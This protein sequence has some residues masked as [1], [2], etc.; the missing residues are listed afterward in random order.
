MR[1]IALL[2]CLA[3]S[4]P[5]AAQ[6][7][8][9]C[10]N[11]QP[12]VGVGNFA[13]DLTLAA[14]DGVGD[15]LC[16]AFGQNNIN[17]D[18]WYSWVAP[19]SGTYRFQ[20]C[21]LTSVD[22]KIAVYD[23]SCAGVVIGCN[24]D[25]CSLQSQVEFPAVAGNTYVLRVGTYPGA[26]VGVG[27]F[28][29]N[30]VPPPTVLSTAVSPI[31]GHTYHLIGG[32]SWTAAENAAVALGGHLAT[33][34]SQAEHDWL[35]QTFANYQGSTVDL[36]IGFN[37]AALEGT[38][39]WSSGE[40]VVYTNWDVG[41]PNNAGGTEDYANLRKN[42]PAGYW[43]DLANAPTGYHANPFGVV[44]ILGNYSAFCKADGTDPLVTTPCPCGN[45]GTAGSGCANSTGS[46]ALLA[47]SGSTT[48][49]TLVFTVS[50]E[51]PTALSI[52]L[53]GNSTVA[54]GVPFGDGVR[55]VGGTLKRL[56]VKNA[57]GGVVSAP[58]PGDDPVATRSANLGDVIPAGA[59]R[60]YQ[61]YSRDPNTTFCAAPQGSTFNISNGIKVQ[62]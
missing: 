10:A 44:E 43:N 39:V 23:G 19:S 61:V 34:R 3:L 2:P 17:S 30:L 21:S 20:T 52:F 27:N 35:V 24:D 47:A 31:N 51:L 4:L 58:A 32:G 28:D 57:S 18:V 29:L 42:N 9:L 6:G 1:L 49:D 38:F 55:C 7:A 8:D 46:G 33:V 48:P 40:P 25:T 50:G 26:V 56:Y 14:T 60:Y 36:W 5:A 53:Q 11:A 37:D 45:T 41:E 22:T 15:N 12:I 54:A 13:F 59:L 16:L 62:W